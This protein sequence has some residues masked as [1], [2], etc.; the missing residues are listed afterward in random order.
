[1]KNKETEKEIKMEINITEIIIVLNPYG[2]DLLSLQ[3]DLPPTTPVVSEEKCAMDIRCA[4]NT[5][6]GYCKK[7][8]PGIPIRIVSRESR[9]G[10]F[11]GKQ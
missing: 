4:K 2:G 8:F 3:T 11:Q 7:N 5:G 9:L 10:S 1:V 6:E